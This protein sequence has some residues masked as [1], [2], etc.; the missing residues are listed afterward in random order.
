MC[1]RY[2]MSVFNIW[3]LVCVHRKNSDPYYS[4]APVTSLPG[5][6]VM[7]KGQRFAQKHEVISK[8]KTLQVKI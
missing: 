6:S 8:K 3:P 7:K 2:N 5:T 4:I 1:F